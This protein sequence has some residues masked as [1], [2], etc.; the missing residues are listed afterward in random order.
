MAP[1][2]LW[3]TPPMI[4]MASMLLSRK[5][6]TA[7]ILRNTKNPMLVI[8]V[9]AMDIAVDMVVAMAMIMVIIPMDMP[10]AMSM[11]SKVSKNELHIFKKLILIT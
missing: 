6:V 7:N 11:L 4:T 10:P 8:M 1:L 5:L 2:V 3:N 9:M